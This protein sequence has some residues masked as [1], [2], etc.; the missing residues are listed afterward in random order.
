MSFPL[1]LCWF[2]RFRRLKPIQDKVVID[3]VLFRGVLVGNVGLYHEDRGLPFVVVRTSCGELHMICCDF[4]QLL[5]VLIF[6]SGH[7]REILIVSQISQLYIQL[8]HLLE[9]C[10][11]HRTFS[12]STVTR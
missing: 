6:D 1:E 5:V 12:K 8:A 9:T 4:W 3:S 11:L 10:S 7:G 2:H